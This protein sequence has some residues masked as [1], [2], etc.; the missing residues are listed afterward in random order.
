VTMKTDRLRLR[1]WRDDDLAGWAA[2]NGDPQVREFFPGGTDRRAVGR[3][4]EPLPGR[5]RRARPGLVGAG[6]RGHRR[7]IGMAGLDPVDEGLPIHR[8]S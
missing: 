7:F 5:H 8:S 3:V 6:G 1:Q 4:A 2:M